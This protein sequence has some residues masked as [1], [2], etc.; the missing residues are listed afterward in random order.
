M[1]PGPDY[2]VLG[3]DG[4][5]YGPVSVEQIRRWIAEDRMEKKTPVKPPGAK[6]WVFL[7]PCRNL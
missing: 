5:E 6:D 4:R 1:I 7:D 2:M 3:G